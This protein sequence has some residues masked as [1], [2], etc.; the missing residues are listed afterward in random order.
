MDADTRRKISALLRKAQGRN[1][2][3]AE[4]LAAAEMAAKL[5]RQYGVTEEDV[6]YDEAD[7]PLKTKGHSLRD[8]LLPVIGRCTNSAPILSTNWTPAVTFLGHAPGP[9]IA[10][11]L[12]EVCYRAVDHEIAHF[13]ETP[14]YKRRRNLRTK[15]QAVQDF[16]VGLITRLSVRL[17]AMFADSMSGEAHAKARSVLNTRFPGAESMNMSNRQVRYGAAAE[18]GFAAGGR[19]QL[20]HGVNGGQERRQIAGQR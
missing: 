20:S 10:A 17:E 8:R 14:E 4:A 1:A 18:R 11:Y 5:M 16:T 12:V 9:E 13:K 15:R 2:S 3:E 19:V 7:A 6:E